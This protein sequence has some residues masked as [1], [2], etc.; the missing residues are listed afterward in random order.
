MGQGSVLVGRWGRRKVET[1]DRERQRDRGK[2]AAKRLFN[3][4]PS[5]FVAYLIRAAKQA[6]GRATTV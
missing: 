4:W 2:R 1:G 3:S 6:G 5:P